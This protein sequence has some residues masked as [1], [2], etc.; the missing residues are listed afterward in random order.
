M[1]SDQCQAL[2]KVGLFIDSNSRSKMAVKP[3]EGNEAMPSFLCAG[4]PVT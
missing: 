2:Q 4:K 1:V 3:K